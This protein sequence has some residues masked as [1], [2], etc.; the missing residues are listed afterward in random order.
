[1]LLPLV[2]AAPAQQPS[3]QVTVTGQALALH[4]FTQG[5][6]GLF[7]LAQPA[8]IVV[9]TDFD[10]R[11]VDVRPKSAGVAAIIGPDHH[12]VSFRLGCLGRPIRTL[13]EGKFVIESAPG[14]ELRK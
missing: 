9:H 14:F 2:A 4:P 3:C 6:F 11:W 13:A 1:M 12:T 8:E 5:A 7:E 10:V